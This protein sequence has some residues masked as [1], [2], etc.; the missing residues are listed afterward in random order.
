MKEFKPSVARKLGEI[1]P[2]NDKLVYTRP[3]D[4]PNKGFLPK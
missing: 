1:V 4:M 3:I 2:V